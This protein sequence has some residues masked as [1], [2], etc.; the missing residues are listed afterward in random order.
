MSLSEVEERLPCPP[1]GGPPQ[2]KGK[3]VEDFGRSFARKDSGSQ[4]KAKQVNRRQAPISNARQHD[5]HS[6]SGDELDIL[7]QTSDSNARRAVQ[8]KSKEKRKEE[9]YEPEFGHVGSNQKPQKKTIADLGLKF[10]K[11]KGTTDRASD[12]TPVNTNP[13]LDAPKEEGTNSQIFLDS[14]P[15][16]PRRS[17]NLDS[18]NKGPST[19]RHMP[20]VNAS[21]LPEKRTTTD[22]PKPRLLRQAKSPQSKPTTTRNARPQPRPSGSQ[23]KPQTDFQ[24]GAALNAR[25]PAC[26]HTGSEHRPFPLSPPDSENVDP[27]NTR[28]SPPVE[29]PTPAAF[30]LLSPVASPARPSAFPSLTPLFSPEERARSVPKKRVTQGSP[31]TPRITA[32]KRGKDTNPF[33]VLSPLSSLPK[34]ANEASGRSKVKTKC[35]SV[36][37]CESEDEDS[38]VE[39]SDQPKAQPFPMSTQVLNSIGTHDTPLRAGPSRQGKRSSSDGTDT[40]QIRKRIKKSRTD[41]NMWVSCSLS[42]SLLSFRTGSYLHLM[43]ILTTTTILVCIHSCTVFHQSFH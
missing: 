10:K 31:K 12:L 7:T 1:R 41:E 16:S 19:S 20:S 42:L 2:R 9:G 26:R 23:S 5:M 21:K 3:A 22:R 24:T 11:N 32:G 25:S 36:Y 4:G 30:P 34:A 28:R 18:R 37:I 43:T 8:K 6:D 40:E 27:S 38:D 29:K 39:G 14:W 13:P 15:P 17:Q 33:P 35:K